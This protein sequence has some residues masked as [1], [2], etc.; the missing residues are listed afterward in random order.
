MEYLLGE[1]YLAG[2]LFMRG[3]KFRVVMLRLGK[4]D[5]LGVKRLV[6]VPDTAP[7]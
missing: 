4:V 6:F 1:A 3:D 2:I 7:H 5:L